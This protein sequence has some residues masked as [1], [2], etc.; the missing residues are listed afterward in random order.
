MNQT[1]ININNDFKTRPDHFIVVTGRAR[2][3]G[4]IYYIGHQLAGALIN[5]ALDHLHASHMR[6]IY[7]TTYRSSDQAVNT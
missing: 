7:F 6:H 4:T 1:T 2:M 5:T 3:V